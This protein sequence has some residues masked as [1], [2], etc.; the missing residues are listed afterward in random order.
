MMNE[1]DWIRATTDPLDFCAECRMH[2]TKC[3]CIDIV[4]DDELCLYCRQSPPMG[5]E[6]PYCSSECSARA[7]GESI[8]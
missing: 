4:L 5:D 7:E 1:D 8:E 2:L 3:E 6:Y